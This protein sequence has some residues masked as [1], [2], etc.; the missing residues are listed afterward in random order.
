MNWAQMHAAIF[1][2]RSPEWTTTY[3]MWNSLWSSEGY[4]PG[5]IVAAV[6]AVSKRIRKPNYASDHFSAMSEELRE[7]RQRYQIS[8]TAKIV[9]DK[10]VCLFC[11]STGFLVVP[12][13]NSVDPHGN[14]S[15]LTPPN[16]GYTFAV[17]CHRCGIA[18]HRGLRGMP[19]DQYETINPNWRDQMAAWDQIQRGRAR[20]HSANGGL[21]GVFSRIQ[22][23][24]KTNGY[25]GRS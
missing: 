19:L 25:G 10:G 6:N 2:H 3:Q 4:Q 17:T 12:H 23:R 5:E 16:E 14:W 9:A 13:L 1:G 21:D 7:A 15:R 20:V 18:R 22:T 8:A 11:G 24:I